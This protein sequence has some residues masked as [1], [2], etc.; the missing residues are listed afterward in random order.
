MFQLGMKRK[1]E[2][3]AR[4]GISVTSSSQIKT[5]FFLALP[6]K[7]YILSRTFLSI[8]V[9]MTCPKVWPKSPICSD[10]TLHPFPFLSTSRV[11]LLSIYFVIY[12]LPIQVE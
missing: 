11:V 4:Y 3:S 9:L 10:P 7:V 5:N 1:L 6:M 8:F 12:E 2:S